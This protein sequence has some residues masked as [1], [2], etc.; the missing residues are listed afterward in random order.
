MT[1]LFTRILGSFS[2][3]NLRLN[4]VCG[5]GAHRTLLLSALSS[6]FYSEVIPA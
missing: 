2:V 6:K 4:H 3:V 1:T 5:R